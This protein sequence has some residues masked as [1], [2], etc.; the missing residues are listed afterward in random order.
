MRKKINERLS[1]FYIHNFPFLNIY[2]KKF[3]HKATLGIGG[4]IGD[5]KRNFKKLF[6]LLNQNRDILVVATSPIL[7]NPPF[8]YLNQPYFYNGVIHIYTKMNPKKLLKYLLKLERR[9]KRKREFKNAPR[10]LDLDIIFFDDKKIDTKELKVPHPKWKERVSV[11][12]PLK[13]S[14]VNFCDL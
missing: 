1:L 7:K 5:V 6:K 13:L 14:G 2:R 9:F 4:N 10:T 11:T 8:G 3:P 12:I